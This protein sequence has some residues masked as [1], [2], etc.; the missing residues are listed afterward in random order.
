MV[1][2][3][4]W[5]KL[6][7]SVRTLDGLSLMSDISDLRPPV[8]YLLPLTSSHLPPASSLLP[9]PFFL[10]PPPSHSLLLF[11][12]LHPPSFLLS[13]PTSYLFSLSLTFYLLP[14]LFSLFL[15]SSSLLPPSS[16]LLPPTFSSPLPPVY[17]AAPAQIYLPPRIGLISWP[18]TEIQITFRSATMSFLSSTSSSSS[19]SPTPLFALL[20]PPLLPSAGPAVSAKLPSGVSEREQL[21]FTNND[22]ACHASFSIRHGG[23]GGAVGRA[24][25]V[26]FIKASPV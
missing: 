10:L 23:P 9:S 19:R 4:A 22:E 16:Y 1:T 17:L 20:P 2:I 15:L 8:S 25:P 11:S 24:V 12:S 7:A 21:R 3:L 18:N 14:L 5:H 6:R 13:L 26:F